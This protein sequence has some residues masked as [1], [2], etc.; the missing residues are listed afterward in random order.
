MA[1]RKKTEQDG[2]P[3]SDV[4][5]VAVTE[6]RRL[7]D[8][9]S[10]SFKGLRTKILTFI[11]AILALLTFLYAGASAAGSDEASV[12]E[13]LFIPQELYGVIFY[14]VGLVCLVYALAKLIHGARPGARWHAPLELQDYELLSGKDK[15]KFLLHLKDDY[16]RTTKENLRT[17]AEKS[18]AVQGSF[19]PLL[20]GAIL[21][22]VLRYFQ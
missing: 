6:Q 3:S 1:V 16:V 21:L 14:F 22:V 20:L 17:H 12:R 2:A 5:E 13:R 19:Y 11:G 4:L 8:E 10:S 7:H 15:Q 18:E 9:L